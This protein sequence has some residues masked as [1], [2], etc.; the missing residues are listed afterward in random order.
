V[1]VFVPAEP[2]LVRPPVPGAL[3]CC[4]CPSLLP[5]PIGRYTEHQ[6]LSHLYLNEKLNERRH[7]E[8]GLRFLLN[9]DIVVKRKKN[10]RRRIGERL[11][12]ESPKTQSGASNIKIGAAE[13]EKGDSAD[14]FFTH[15]PK[16]L[17]TLIVRVKFFAVAEYMLLKNY[18]DES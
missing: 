13:L 16:N 17:L 7:T 14:T 12:Q 9:A 11:K 2:K 10:V 1:A 15:I 4:H 8:Y 3:S 5:P 6:V 18:E